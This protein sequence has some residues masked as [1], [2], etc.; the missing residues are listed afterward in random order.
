MKAFWGSYLFMKGDVALLLVLGVVGS[1][2]MGWFCEGA[3]P[4]SKA[5]VPSAT[6]LSSPR[7]KSSVSLEEAL[8][9]RRSLRSFSP[10]SISLEDLTQL[11]WAGQGQT[12]QDSGLRTAPS[13][14]ALYPL[15]LYLVS[16]RGVERYQ[17]RGHL[18]EKLSEVDLRKDLRKAALNQ[19]VLASAPLVV[20]ITGVESKTSV[21]YGRRAERYLFLEA[22]HV[23]QNILLQ[24]VALGLS[25]VPIGAFHDQQVATV[26]RLPAG[27]VPLYLLAVGRKP[28]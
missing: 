13:A 8:L 9:W 21:K 25:S 26:L 24:A 19:G 4:S 12:Q 20:V 7:L 18:L 2:L 15:L 28:S 6:K 14:G 17:P 27:E 16:A 1:L 11:C 23:A 22:G 5:K 3:S 10:E